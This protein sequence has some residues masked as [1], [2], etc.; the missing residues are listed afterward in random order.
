MQNTLQTNTLLDLT[1]F[2]MSKHGIQ[3]KILHASEE[4]KAQ[5]GDIVTVDYT[6]YLLK[7]THEIGQKFDSS[8]DRNQ[9]FSFKLGYGQVIEGWELSVADM[10]IDEERIVILP[11][12]LAYGE[13][14]IS[15]IPAHASLIFVI[16]LL[17]I[18]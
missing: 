15:I 6:G 18:E 4:P 17:A 12:H 3:Y 13:H 9:P 5:L 16:K 1:Q 7:G 14:A 8:L 10:R 11:S 2:T